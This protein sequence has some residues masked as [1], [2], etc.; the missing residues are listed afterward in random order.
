MKAISEII[1]KEG[2]RDLRR[3]F[4]ECIMTGRMDQVE[5]LLLEYGLEM[6]YVEQLMW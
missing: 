1:G 2:E 6:D 3:D 4:N 5:D